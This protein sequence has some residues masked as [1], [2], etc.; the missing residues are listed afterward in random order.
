MLFS[1]VTALLG[2]GT[3]LLILFPIVM[4]FPTVVKRGKGAG[5]VG[6]EDSGLVV[7]ERVGVEGI[8]A[9]CGLV[10]GAQ[11]F[12]DGLLLVK[13]SGRALAESAIMSAK[14]AAAWSTG[15]VNELFCSVA[16]A[17]GVR[18][19][20]DKA[21]DVTGGLLDAGMAAPTR[22]RLRLR[23]DE[24]GPGAVACSNHK[25]R[26]LTGRDDGSVHKWADC[27]REGADTTTLE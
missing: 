13:S 7:A 6:V 18:A 24:D 11:V 2:W 21:V 19:G 14:A 25:S 27:S 3:L 9:T 10:F 20:V 15:M 12:R 4:L 22:S 23:L 8:G 17:F 5:G 26:A 16:L 1:A